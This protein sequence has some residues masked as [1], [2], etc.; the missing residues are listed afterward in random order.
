[1]AG[2]QKVT[3]NYQ[4]DAVVNVPPIGSQFDATADD[5]DKTFTVPGNELWKLNFAQ[6]VLTT[7]ATVGD[8]VVTVV[9][10]D[11]DGNILASIIAGAVQAASVA[12]IKYT[13]WGGMLRETS[14]VNGE[15]QSSIPSD[16]YVESGASIRFYDSAAVSA[17]GD[18]MTVSFQ[19]QKFTV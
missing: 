14:V 15:L 17:A 5:S 10:S 13:F 16:L 1:M 18:D 6:V 9:I 7:D 11:A 19:Y 8:R 2:T 3:N 4:S 12:D